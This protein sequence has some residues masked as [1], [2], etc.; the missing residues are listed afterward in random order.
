[1]VPAIPALATGGLIGSPFTDLY[2]SVWGAAWFADQQPG[3]PTWSHALAAP[4]GMGF[5]YS[6]PLH[7]W[8]TWLT[9]PL[10]GMTASWNTG[11]LAA[12]VATVACAY[13]AARAWGLQV[14]GALVAAAVY[15][16]SP[17]FHGFAV[18]GIVE[19]LDGWTLALWAWA[20]GARKHGWAAL[21]L[22]LTVISSWYLGAVGCAL[23]VCAGR[24]G[25]WSLLG[26][27]LAVPFLWAFGGAFPERAAL[28]PALRRAMG[29]QLG[30][31]RPGVLEGLQPFAKTSWVGLTAP[32]LAL[33][34]ARKRPE[35][36]AVAVGCALL[37]FGWAVVYAVPGLS[38][39]RFPYR[40]MLGAVACVAMLA[41]AT[42]Q[43]WRWGALLAPTI[44]LEGLLLSPIEPVLPSAPADADPVYA[45]VSPGQVVL[46]IPGALALPPGEI[47][48]SRPRARWFL[49]HQVHHGGVTAWAPDFNAI[50]TAAHDGLDA[51]R[52]LDPA[53]GQPAPDRLHVPPTVDMVVLHPLELRGRTDTARALLTAEGWA[54]KQDG[55]RELWTR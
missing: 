54:L 23:A 32:I 31:W 6:S 55:E 12:R 37:S 36:A 46:D 38:A 18:E 3:L 41:G 26:L 22:G 2:P 25:W 47:N 4:D 48:P 5:Y 9:R 45:H 10:M 8:W 42:A 1:M 24:R 11:V 13:G 53:S 30:G 28:E 15:G 16:C 50:G 52:A 17:I 27:G 21:A 39:M 33:I 40:W 7:G 35:L 14:S 43:Q 51:V 49:Y 29:T 44:V 20:V 19:G 34:A